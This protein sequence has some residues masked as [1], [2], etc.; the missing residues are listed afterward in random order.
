M[1]SWRDSLAGWEDRGHGGPVARR[2]SGCHTNARHARHAHAPGDGASHLVSDPG[3]AASQHVHR[4]LGNPPH[5]GTWC[6]PPQQPGQTRKRCRSPCCCSCSRR[7]RFAQPDGRAHAA[8]LAA[9]AV[10]ASPWFIRRGGTTNASVAAADTSAGTGSGSGHLPDFR[11]EP[12]RFSSRSPGCYL[13]LFSFTRAPRYTLDVFQHLQHDNLAQRIFARAHCC[14]G[15]AC[16]HGHATSRPLCLRHRRQGHGGDTVNRGHRG[17]GYHPSEAGGR[18]VPLRVQR[19][20]SGSVSP[21]ELGPKRTV[22][23]RGHERGRE[24]GRSVATEL[25]PGGLCGAAESSLRVGVRHFSGHTWESSG[26][27]PSSKEPAVRMGGNGDDVA[28]HPTDASAHVSFLA[29]G[30][31]GVAS[32]VVGCLRDLL[33]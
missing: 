2:S 29:A 19:Q 24:P 27:P 21:E 33:A 3:G 25:T 8:G 26:G 11:P 10:P 12:Q 15:L 18:A 23:H 13:V 7:R 1:H 14:W 6:R 17:S 20:P 9:R 28:P 4:R 5:R 22:R 16:I 32:A 31:A 30:A